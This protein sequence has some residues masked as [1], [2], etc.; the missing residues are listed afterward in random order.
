[1]FGFSKKDI[2]AIS[3]KCKSLLKTIITLCEHTL[4]MDINK[5]IQDSSYAKTILQKELPIMTIMK[6]VFADY[7]ITTRPTGTLVDIWIL[8]KEMQYSNDTY[9][10]MPPHITDTPRMVRKELRELLLRDKGRYL[11]KLKT[12]KKNLAKVKLIARRH[13]EKIS[14]I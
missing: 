11:H 4:V 1:M 9:E 2:P 13:K 7:L 14:F 12:Q 6:K 8:K 5:M 10:N 3:P